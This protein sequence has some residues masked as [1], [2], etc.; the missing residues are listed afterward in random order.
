MG[1]HGIVERIRVFGDVE[2]FLD[3][4]AGVGKERPLGTDAAAVFIRFG[5]VVCADGDKPAVGDLKFAMELHEA[6]GLTAVLGAEA[7]AAK[8]ENHG[9]LALQ[10]GELATFRGVVGKFVI[11]KLRAGNDV[12]SHGSTSGVGCTPPADVS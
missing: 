2:I 12:G 9:M 6:F 4:P 7:S 3:D 5:D 1:D 11:G 8:D 10:F